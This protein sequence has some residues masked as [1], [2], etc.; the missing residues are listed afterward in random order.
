[1]NNKDIRWQQRFENL[2]KA[3]SLLKE[4]VD[5]YPNLSDLEKEGMVQRFE[6]TFEL[7]W[8]TIKDYLESKGI[9]EKFPRDI[10]KSAFKT[11]I[12]SDEETWISILDNRN[13]VSHTYDRDS[14]TFAVNNISGTYYKAIT[15]LIGFLN[16][17]K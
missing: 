13:L 11:N 5:L 16:T 7:A 10:I 3:Y 15:E 14:F 6:Y 8:N 17:Q 1:M 12:I 9:E 4:V 2:K